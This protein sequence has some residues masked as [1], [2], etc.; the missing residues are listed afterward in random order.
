MHGHYGV[1][2]ITTQNLEVAKVDVER[3]LIM[4]KG[5]VPGSKGGYVMVRDAV[6]RARHADAPYPAALVE[7]QAAG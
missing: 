3:G 5:A 4:I 7:A 1:D 2:N 6:K